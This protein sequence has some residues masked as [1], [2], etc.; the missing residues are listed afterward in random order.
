MAAIDTWNALCTPAQLYA[1]ISL[2]TIVIMAFQRQFKGIIAQGLFAA[3]WTFVLGWICNKGWTGL[4][5]FLVLLPVI[6]TVMA[7]L[8][9]GAA[10]FS[11]KE[12]VQET[13]KDAKAE[14]QQLMQQ[15]AAQQQIQR[16]HFY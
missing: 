6:L 2:V 14:G 9:L 8:A 13:V 12:A 10:V 5:W 16:E 7:L 11:V 15:A 4:S 1:I 3:L